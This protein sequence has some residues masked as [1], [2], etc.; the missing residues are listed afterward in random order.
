M[1]ELLDRLPNM[2]LNLSLGIGLAFLI[3]SLM[4]RLE[5][6]SVYMRLFIQFTIDIIIIVYINQILAMLN[7]GDL[8]SSLFFIP[9]F[10]GSQTSLQESIRSLKKNNQ[11]TDIF[12]RDTLIQKNKIMGYD[13]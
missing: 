13:I 9:I 6:S 7:I 2:Y 10:M 11:I 3:D 4:D 5:L 12:T 8:T 1:N